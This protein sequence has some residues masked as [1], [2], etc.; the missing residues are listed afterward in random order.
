MERWTPTE[1]TPQGAVI[2]PLLANIYLHPLDELMAA[3]RLSD[4]ALCR[5]LRGSVPEPRGSRG[6]A[7]QVAA[8]V[9]AN[10][11]TPASRQDADR[12]LPAAGEGFDFLGYGSKRPAL[13]AQEEPR[14]AQGRHPGQDPTHARG[15]ACGG[16]RRS[17]PDAEGLV[18]LLQARP[19]ATSTRARRVH[20]ATAARAPAQAGE[21]TGLRHAAKPTIG[22]GPMPSSRMRAVHPS[23]SLAATRDTP[24]EETTDWRAV[25]GKTARTVR[26]AGRR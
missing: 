17:Q 21:A 23:H 19:P 26:R 13:C 25:C 6:G 24:D 2:S 18:R 22:A 15:T 11:L 3:Q 9:E 1:G 14:P 16:H 5:R 10:G 12:R 7:G 20:P 8:W 4:G